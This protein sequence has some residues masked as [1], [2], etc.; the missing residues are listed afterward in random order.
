MSSDTNP[1]S[2]SSRAFA[3]D[4]TF[5][6]AETILQF[7]DTVANGSDICERRH[8]GGTQRTQTGTYEKHDAIKMSGWLEWSREGRVIRTDMK[9]VTR[10]SLTVNLAIHVRR[11]YVRYVSY[12]TCS[13]LP[14][15]CSL[16]ILTLLNR[17]GWER[18]LY[19]GNHT[20]LLGLRVRMR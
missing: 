8:L 20:S 12:L 19:H 9:P 17:P 6:L 2:S 1:D 7:H 11:I 5:L 10:Q 15:C 16:P 18:P 3:F 4:K 13:C 14:V